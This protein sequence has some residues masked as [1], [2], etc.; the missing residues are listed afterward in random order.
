ME[1]QN[2]GIWCILCCSVWYQLF[3]EKILLGGFTNS[4]ALSTATAFKMFLF[5]RNYLRSDVNGVCVCVWYDQL[6]SISNLKHS[7]YHEEWDSSIPC[8]IFFIK[9]IVLCRSS[10]KNGARAIVFTETDKHWFDWFRN[11]QAL[12]SILVHIVSFPGACLYV[13]RFIFVGGDNQRGA[14]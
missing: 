10:F 5:K 8:C 11:L 4:R 2:V 13:R 1:T 6:P 3:V 12:A 7:S 14:N 9:A